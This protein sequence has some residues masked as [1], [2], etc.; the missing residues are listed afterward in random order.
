MDMRMKIKPLAPGMEHFDT[1]NLCAKIFPVPGKLCQRFCRTGKQQTIQL[2]LIRHEKRIQ[3]CR[4]RKDD[5]KVLD[6]QQIEALVFNPAFFQQRLT[7]G[8]MT[9]PAGVI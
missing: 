4:N 5:V 7:F 1:A 6:I 2:F 8:T 3:F 9:V